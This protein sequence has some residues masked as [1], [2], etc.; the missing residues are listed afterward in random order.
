MKIK[1]QK[2]YVLPIPRRPQWQ[3]LPS[4]DKQYAGVADFSRSFLVQL[5]AFLKVHFIALAVRKPGTGG[6][7]AA[8]T[9]SFETAIDFRF[10]KTEHFVVV[11]LESNY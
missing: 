1:N 3:F 11:A 6:L 5:E 10:M 2:T 8:Y 7:C 9:A 4:F